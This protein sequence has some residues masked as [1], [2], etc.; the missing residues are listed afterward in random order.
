MA[1]ETPDP[2]TTL[3]ALPLDSPDWVPFDIP[4]RW[5]AE[6]TG[7]P[8]LAAHDLTK[9][10]TIPPPDGVRS[11]VRIWPYE[12]RRLLS[13]SHWT[14]HYVSWNILRSG[15]RIRVWPARL[16]NAT[17]PEGPIHEDVH[18]AWKPDLMR[19]WPDMFPPAFETATKQRSAA[20]STG[21]R[22]K[23]RTDGGYQARRVRAKLRILEKKG[24]LLDQYDEIELRIKVRRMF[25][26]KP[27]DGLG[28]PSRQVIN[29]TIR[30]YLAER[31]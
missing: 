30:D 8:D 5:L 3:P 25:P 11:M 15:S 2:N 21:Q 27:K 24:S 16:H 17:G 10:L 13:S 18:Y 29:Q 1:A 7:N 6:R 22:S 26:S 12:E 14:T 23:R 20:A 31:E 19:V 28:N 4:H 9:V